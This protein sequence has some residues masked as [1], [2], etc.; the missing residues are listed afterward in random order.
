[1]PSLPGVG[2]LVDVAA[3]SRR[4]LAHTLVTVAAVLVIVMV[5]VIV[6]VIMMM[7]MMMMTVIYLVSHA[8]QCVVTT[9]GP[10]CAPPP[11]A[12][13]TCSVPHDVMMKL[14]VRLLLDS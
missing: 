11:A 13:V 14:R 7:M 3:P 12:G 4:A 9:P 10:G 1:M 5:M 8:A 2:A 6:M